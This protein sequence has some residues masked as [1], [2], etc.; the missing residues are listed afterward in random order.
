[1]V[2]VHDFF[3][4]AQTHSLFYSYIRRWWKCWLNDLSVNEYS[5]QYAQ[6]PNNECFLLHL[7]WFVQPQVWCVLWGGD[8]CHWPVTDV[9]CNPVSMIPALCCHFTPGSICFGLFTQTDKMS[10]FSWQFIRYTLLKLCLRSVYVQILDD[11]VC[12]AVDLY[13]FFYWQIFISGQLQMEAS[14]LI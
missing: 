5:L 3:L 6:I 12:G 8:W 4:C 2:H 11:S 14:V 9:N 7:I 10:T 13:F 1:M